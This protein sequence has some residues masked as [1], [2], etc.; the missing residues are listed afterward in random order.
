MI[1]I[2]NRVQVVQERMSRLLTLARSGAVP[3]PHC[4]LLPR[5]EQSN[6]KLTILESKSFPFHK[7]T[8]GIVSLKMITVLS[9]RSRSYV[10]RERPDF[11][12]SRVASVMPTAYR[13]QA[14]E[15]YANRAKQSPG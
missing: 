11:N 15:R 4:C 13:L 2:Y 12:E 5:S 14:Y 3:R 8:N 9:I 1:G 6:K 10:S 7:E